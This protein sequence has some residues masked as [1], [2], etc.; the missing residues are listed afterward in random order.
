MVSQN[1]RTSSPKNTGTRAADK[2]KKSKKIKQN[3]N[4]NT[5]SEKA[6]KSIF[7][8]NDHTVQ[9]PEASVEQR[10]SNVGERE[11]QVPRDK[12]GDEFTKAGDNSE[13]KM[14]QSNTLQSAPSESSTTLMKMQHHQVD[15]L[16]INTGLLDQELSSNDQESTTTS[17]PDSS[18]NNYGQDGEQDSGKLPQCNLEALAHC[19]DY[20]LRLAV[21]AASKDW[22]SKLNDE[23]LQALIMEQTKT[24]CF[25]QHTQPTTSFEKHNN[26][27][28]FG[29]WH[30]QEAHNMNAFVSAMPNMSLVKLQVLKFLQKISKNFL[31]IESLG[32]IAS[33]TSGAAASGENKIQASSGEINVSKN[34]NNEQNKKLRSDNP[35]ADQHINNP[36]DKEKLSSSQINDQAPCPS[37]EMSQEQD[38]DYLLRF[39][40]QLGLI[41]TSSISNC[42]SSHEEHTGSIQYRIGQAVTGISHGFCRW[43]PSKLVGMGSDLQRVVVQ[44]WPRGVHFQKTEK[45]L[46]KKNNKDRQRVDKEQQQ[47]D[48][49]YD[50]SGYIQNFTLLSR[51]HLLQVNMTLCTRDILAMG[52]KQQPGGTATLC[53]FVCVAMCNFFFGL[54]W[55][56]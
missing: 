43:T 13:N 5:G 38:L 56:A 47:L 34:R 20:P 8:E 36:S 29:K 46:Q 25:G 14:K 51:S 16:H 33:S 49:M 52:E 18:N 17:I 22:C 27:D 6:E 19:C 31:T 30:L 35:E 3:S 48:M 37:S 4:K 26:S 50:V 24:S 28:I 10:R 44:R 45:N 39:T 11:E 2:S 21:S 42:I 7:S 1:A 15:G 23:Q 54:E 40:S 41:Q 32:P 55:I 12:Q 53:I 9:A